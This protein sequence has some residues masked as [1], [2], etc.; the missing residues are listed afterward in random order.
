MTLQQAVETVIKKCGGLR[1]AARESE[2]DVGYLC[3]LRKGRKTNPHEIYLDRMG[4]ERVVS[5]RVRKS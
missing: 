2:I 1:K 5:Y 4:I 3:N